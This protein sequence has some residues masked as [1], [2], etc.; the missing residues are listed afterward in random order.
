MSEGRE[1][2]SLREFHD[3]GR[4]IRYSAVIGIKEASS[5]QILDGSHRAV[6][7]TT[8]GNSEMEG[9]VGYARARPGTSDC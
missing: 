5:V 8:R 1:D 9:Y 2:P 6:V 3:D 7:L 4:K